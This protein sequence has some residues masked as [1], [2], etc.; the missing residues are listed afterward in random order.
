M[1]A[2]SRTPEHSRVVRCVQ[3]AEPAYQDLGD[4]CTTL[5]YVWAGQI[6]RCDLIPLTRQMRDQ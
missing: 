3:L 5:E 4:A 1:D 2:Q 6:E